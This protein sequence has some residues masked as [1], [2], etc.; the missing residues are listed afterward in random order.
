VVGLPFGMIANAPAPI[1]KRG[2]IALDPTFD[3]EGL[4]KMLIDTEPDIP[5]RVAVVIA[6]HIIIGRQYPKKDG[7]QSQTVLYSRLNLV[8][9]IYSGRHYP[10]LEKAQLGIVWKRTAIE[11][12]LEAKKVAGL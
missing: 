1:W 3:P 8:I 5:S 6:R 12:T 10:D 7:S 2:S 9:G 4:P 11:Q